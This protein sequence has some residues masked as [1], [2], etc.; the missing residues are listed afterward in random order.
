MIQIALP[1]VCT[2]RIVIAILDQAI[3]RVVR[4]VW[5]GCAGVVFE[6]VVGGHLASVY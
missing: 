5:R 3:V 6:S 4:F 1:D 2:Y